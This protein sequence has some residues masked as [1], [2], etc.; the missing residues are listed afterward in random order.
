MSLGGSAPTALMAFAPARTNRMGGGGRRA[1]L[2][3]LTR[4]GMIA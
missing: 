3:V 2:S 1:A 4:G